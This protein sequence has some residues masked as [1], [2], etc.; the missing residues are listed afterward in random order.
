M[1]V[2]TGVP[3]GLSGA[4]VAVAA[5]GVGAGVAAGVDVAAEAQ[6]DDEARGERQRGDGSNDRAHHVPPRPTVPE[7]RRG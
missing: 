3:V 2:A 6:A 7:V 5:N 4:G 1:G